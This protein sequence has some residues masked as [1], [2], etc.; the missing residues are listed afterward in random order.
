MPEVQEDEDL[1]LIPL[2]NVTP[3]ILKQESELKELIEDL[4]RMGCKGFLAKPWKLQ[5]EATL[6]EFLSERGNHWERTMQQVLEQWTTEVW[7]D[8]YEFAPRKG[9]RRANR[10]DTYFVGKFRT[11]HDPKDGFHPGDCNN[12]KERRVIEFLLPIL[13]PKKPKRLSITMANTIFGALSKTR[14]INWGR[15]IQELVEKSIPHIDKKPSSFSPYILHIYQRSGCIKE[16]KEDALTIAEDEV[17]Y[18]LGPEVEL[19][20]A[21]TE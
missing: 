8:V 10:K 9:E 11:E 21:G 18:K 1:V 16:K 14:P 17:V 2:K 6:R 15:L 19:T 12:T 4:T 3:A 5:S 20:K 13:Y 7:A